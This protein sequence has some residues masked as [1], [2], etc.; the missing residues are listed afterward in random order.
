MTNGSK[1][2][3]QVKRKNNNKEKLVFTN[4]L[5][6]IKPYAV[7]DICVVNFISRF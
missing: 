4:D 1:Q 2:L 6:L 7:Y 5:N 3:R